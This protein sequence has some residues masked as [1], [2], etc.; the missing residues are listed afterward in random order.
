M[1]LELTSNPSHEDESKVIDKIREFNLDLVPTHVER[2]CVFDR[3]DSGEVIGG[4]VG[5]TYWGYLDISYLWVDDSYRNQGRAT[6]IVRMAEEEAIRRGCKN[7]QVD[8]YSFQALDFYKK[9]GYSEFGS[10]DG[11]SG[12]HVRHYLRKYLQPQKD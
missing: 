7:A 6:L 2:L 11:V 5:K 1:N 3:L 4:L 10:I 8:T 12:K 9:L